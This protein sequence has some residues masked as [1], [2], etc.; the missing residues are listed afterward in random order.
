MPRTRRN[1]GF[2][3][4]ELM[5][6]LTIVG[7]LSAIAIPAWNGYA[8]RA[9]LAN[10]VSILKETRLRMEQFYADNRSYG[11]G[12][13]CAVADFHDSD[14]KFDIS[15]TLQAGGQQ[16]LLTATGVGPSAGFAYT[17]D[18][19]GIEATTGVPAGWY[20]GSLPASRFIVRKE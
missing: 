10:G 18:D 9:R 16:Y 6:I 14:G 19:A 12:G 11:S 20:S 1:A 17:I 7:I 4:I 2:T 5:I 3:L 13:G 15:C 8:E